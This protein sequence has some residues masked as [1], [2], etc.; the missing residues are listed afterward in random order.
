MEQ[1][2]VATRSG[3]KHRQS[4]IELLRILMMLS[5][6]AHH[7]VVNS[8]IPEMYDYTEGGICCQ[9]ADDPGLRHVGKDRD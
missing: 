2:T 8:A 9:H 5:L 1:P 6:V 4:N 7:F 3:T